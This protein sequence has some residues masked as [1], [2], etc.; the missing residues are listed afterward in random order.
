MR[1]IALVPLAAL[2]LNTASADAG[3]GCG[4][5][6][7]AAGRQ[8]FE[9]ADTNGDRSLTRAEYEHAGLQKLGVSFEESDLD[10]DGVTSDGEYLELYRKHH[11]P[12]D[13]SEV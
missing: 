5:S 8:I 6:A 13:R 11:P 4:Q 2:L 7:E 10:A 3:E 12:V 9:E 1:T